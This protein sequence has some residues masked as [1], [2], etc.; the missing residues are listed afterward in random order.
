MKF[1]I[2]MPQHGAFS[3]AE[4]ITR[5]ARAA[6]E[7]GWD[8]LWCADHV[9]VPNSFV[10][11]FSPT[12]HEVFT[13][14]GYLAGITERVQLGT[15]VLILPYRH[16]VM[17]AKQI[18]TVDRLAKGRTIFGV[19]FGWIEEEYRVLDIPFSKRGARADEIVAIMKQCWAEGS[20][21]HSGEF[22]SFG[23]FAFEPKP[24]QR[25]HP[26]LW[27]GGNDNKTLER[28]VAYGDGW[29]P[30]T[31][32][33]RPGSTQWT[34]T[35]F[36]QKIAT[37]RNMATEAGRDPASIALSLHAPLAY[38]LDP[39]TFLGDAFS[40]IGTEDQI[41]RNLDSC[42]ELGL[43]HILLNF[44][45]TIPGSIQKTSVDDFLAT[46]ERFAGSIMP[47]FH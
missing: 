10:E 11:R 1:G 19:A 36:R 2:A 38:D 29:H 7:Q 16:P 31:S 39:A 8:S 41:L 28:V 15:S 22:Y 18:A 34:L 9:I 32:A 42:Q 47:R 40:F 25:P 37:L 43:E 13:T 26:P 30:I 5:M 33:K 23:D 27:I 17:T 24:V 46:M 3:S 14:L 44:W 6:E 20:N 12:F 4:S 45:Y 21:A 35:D